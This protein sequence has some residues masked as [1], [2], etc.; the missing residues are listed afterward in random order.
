MNTDQDQ[1]DGYVTRGGVSALPGTR[2]GRVSPPHAAVRRATPRPRK[3]SPNSVGPNT[4]S[5]PRRLLCPAHA[6]LGLAHAGRLPGAG[7]FV[8]LFSSQE[9]EEGNYPLGRSR[10]HPSHPLTHGAA[11]RWYFGTGAR[12]WWGIPQVA[13]VVGALGLLGG[14]PPCKA[15]S[16]PRAL[17]VPRGDGNLEAHSEQP[18]VWHREPNPQQTLQA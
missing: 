2:T 18:S 10:P 9:L 3:Q 16:S 6:V 15:P 4:G 7:L 5:V 8:C 1:I 13:G 11:G 12:C 14:L 17:P